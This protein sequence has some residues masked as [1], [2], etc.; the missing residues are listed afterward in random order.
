MLYAE[1]GRQFT[2]TTG[3]RTVG[4]SAWCLISLGMTS[5][6]SR[7]GGLDSDD[8]MSARVV[9]HR[10]ASSWWR[11]SVGVSRI[12]RMFDLGSQAPVVDDVRHMAA[13]LSRIGEGADDAQ[14]I[15]LI[16]ALEELKGA[17]EGAQAVLA[18]GFDRSQREAE[19]AAGVPAERR[20]RAV[21]GQV[22][23]ARRVSP[24]RGRQQLGLALVLDQEMPCT[25]AALRGGRISEWRAM[26][27]ARE[28]ACLSRADRAMVD[29]RVAGDLDAVQAMSDGELVAAA[30]GLAYELDPVSFVER[31]RR[32]EADRQVSLRPAPEVMSQVTALLP[33]RDG[34]AVWA[35]LVPRGR[36]AAGRGRCAVPGPD[37]GRHLGLPRRPTGAVGQ[38]GVSS[39]ATLLVNVVVSDAVLLGDEHGFGWVQDFGAVP[40]TCCGS[41]SLPT[42]KR[43]W[44]SGCAGSTPPRP[45]VSWWRWTPRPA[46]SRAGWPSSCGCVTGAAAPPTAMPR[47]GTSTTRSTTP[48]ADRPARPTGRGCAR[49]ATTP[50][51]PQAGPPGPGPDPGTPSRRSHRPGTRY[52]S[53][54]PRFTAG[55]R[56]FRIDW[57]RCPV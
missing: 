14:R 26:L 20:G 56:G 23:L 40:V 55:R 54:A 4:D 16:R 37:H 39:P 48:A 35:V 51:R 43:A 47:S 30:R 41:G 42:P 6:I 21:A 2:S 50:N 18:A 44:S 29:E 10:L 17:A 13:A 15:G 33:V 31:R 19:A 25:R 36:P 11:M 32:A 57:F 24:H 7:L 1:V 3:R 27:L 8:V 12:E 5:S 49:A 45:P 53:T 46:G 38:D 52:V 34:V 9:V 22:A 28:T